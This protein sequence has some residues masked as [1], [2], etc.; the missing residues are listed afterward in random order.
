MVDLSDR[1]SVFSFCD[2]TAATGV[3]VSTMA[4]SGSGGSATILS[5]LSV[6]AAA[7]MVVEGGSTTRGIIFECSWATSGSSFCACDVLAF[8]DKRPGRGGI[9]ELFC[10]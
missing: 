7:A 4:G 6:E 3:V 5:S 1:W 9:F 8:L 2:P 10:F